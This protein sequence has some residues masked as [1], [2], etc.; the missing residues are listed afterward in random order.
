MGSS[1]SAVTPEAVATVAMEAVKGIQP[2]RM[3]DRE[4]SAMRV[5]PRERERWYS[6]SAR[7]ICKFGAESL[8]EGGCRR[9]NTCCF[10]DLGREESNY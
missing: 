9:V 3:R 5:R 2:V 1:G 10:A 4:A 8:G 6:K 7:A